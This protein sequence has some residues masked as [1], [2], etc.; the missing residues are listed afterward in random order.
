MCPSRRMH[1][2]HGLAALH[3]RQSL[4]LQL[5]C[6]RQLLLALQA[7]QAGISWWWHK[8]ISCLTV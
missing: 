1:G 2:M 8:N 6:V 5:L 3:V 7:R 4:P